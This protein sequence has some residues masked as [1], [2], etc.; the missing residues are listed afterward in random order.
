MVDLKSDGEP[1]STTQ[2][3]AYLKIYG[4]EGN[5]SD[6]P[7]DVYDKA[8]IFENNRMVMEADLDMANKI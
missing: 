1:A 4:I 2:G 5:H 6:V 8:F 7:A 3:Q